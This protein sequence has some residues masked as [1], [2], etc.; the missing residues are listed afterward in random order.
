MLAKAASLPADAVV[1]DLEDSVPP[2]EKDSARRLVAECLRAW[3][4]DA[5]APYVRISPPR[6]G[7]LATDVQAFAAHST[8]GVVVPKIDRPIELGA[9]F[10]A[11]GREREMIVNLETP[12][13]VLHAEEFADT[14][15]VDGIFLGGEDLTSALGTTRTPEGDELL[16]ARF[17]V[18]TAARAGGIAAYDTICPE[19]RDI[20]V[21][22]DDAH[23]AAAL[24]FDGK[25]AIHPAQIAPIHAAFT[26]PAVE[27]E[28][29]RRVVEAFDD[30]VARGLG[31]VAVDGQMVDPPVADRARALL[32]RAGRYDVTS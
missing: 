24:G 10:D 9:V 15:G 30:A 14:Y 13:A 22:E 21:L 11:A 25:F 16:W 6:F 1:F 28:R 20:S 8:V 17:M 7:M 27:V 5:P 32:R 26:P 19:F 29:A 4:S 2:A 3:P 18:L 31:A 12:R 23:R